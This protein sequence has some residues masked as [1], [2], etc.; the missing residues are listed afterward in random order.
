MRADEP[1]SRVDAALAVGACRSVA[2]RL[3]AA[4]RVAR[5]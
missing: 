1:R 5:I 4:L 2:R 3:S